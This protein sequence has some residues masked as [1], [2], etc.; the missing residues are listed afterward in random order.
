MQVIIYLYGS[1]AVRCDS[2]GGV[3]GAGQVV[4]K[5]S[6]PH[7]NLVPIPT[8]PQT[9]CFSSQCLTRLTVLIVGKDSSRHIRKKN[10]KRI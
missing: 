4:L 3:L 9:Q 10:L 7:A 8:R 1:N 6:S 5:S 2:V